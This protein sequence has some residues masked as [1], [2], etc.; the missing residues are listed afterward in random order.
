MGS[1]GGLCSSPRAWGCGWNVTRLLCFAAIH[2]VLVTQ[3]EVGAWTYHYGN[4]ADYSWEL[5]RNFC[6][7]FY[8]DLVAIQ[9]QGEIAYLN[10]VLPHHKTYYWIGLRKINNVWTWVGTNKALTKEAENWANKEPNN[11]GRN[12][13][14]VEIYIKRDRDAGRWNDENC[15]KKKRAL[16]YQASCQRSSCSQRGECVETIGNY[17]CDCY[18]GFSGPECEHAHD[19]RPMSSYIVPGAAAGTLLFLLVLGILLWRWRP[20]SKEPLQS[21]SEAEMNQMETSSPPADDVTY[22]NL[23]FHKSHAKAEENVNIYANVNRY[24]H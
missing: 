6:R 17:T 3:V 18:P 11:K 14:C 5:A 15:Q 20:C 1:A 2:W 7:S 8:T 4:K 12:L 22:L 21:R 24:H 10:S 19:Q 16:C 9:N 23:N 13:D